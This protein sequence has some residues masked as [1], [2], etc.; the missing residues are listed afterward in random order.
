MWGSKWFRRYLG[1]KELVGPGHAPWSAYE[2]R[3]SNSYFL[4]KLYINIYHIK[5]QHQKSFSGQ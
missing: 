4:A 5:K 3:I 1:L 2:S